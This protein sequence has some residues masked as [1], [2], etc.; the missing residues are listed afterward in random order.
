MTGFP[1]G[2]NHRPLHGDSRAV[3]VARSRAA[4]RDPLR[5]RL[6][7]TA[8]R[9]VV[10]ALV[11]EISHEN[12]RP[13]APLLVEGPGSWMVEAH[14]TVRDVSRELEFEVPKDPGYSTIAG[15]VFLRF[16]QVP[17]AGASFVEEGSE[18]KVKVPES[19][20]R[21]VVRVRLTRSA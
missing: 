21:N 15:L 12:E 6:G 14:T 5:A 1:D 17:A 3:P 16:G 13:A 7:D 2:A 19:T 18:L 9:L 8:F 4:C 11:R 20:P 10:G